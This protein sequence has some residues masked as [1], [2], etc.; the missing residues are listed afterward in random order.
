M[1]Q[2]LSRLPINSLPSASRGLVATLVLVSF[3]PFRGFPPSLEPPGQI[4]VIGYRSSLSF[5]SILFNL[6]FMSSSRAKAVIRYHINMITIKLCFTR[7]DES[8]LTSDLY[9]FCTLSL[10]PIT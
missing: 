8:L 6:S 7:S 4:R 1:S 3:K 10:T 5:E 2:P 9:L